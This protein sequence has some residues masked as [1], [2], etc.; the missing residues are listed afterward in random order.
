M[1]I[2]KTDIDNKMLDCEMEIYKHEDRKIRRMYT[3]AHQNLSWYINSGRASTGWVKAFIR[4]NPKIIMKI[5]A[6]NAGN[7]LDS[8]KSVNQYL[9]KYYGYKIQL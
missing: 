2:S 8:I 4:C 7:N 9:S 1:S 6:K 5:A 3:W